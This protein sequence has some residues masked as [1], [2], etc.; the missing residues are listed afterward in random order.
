MFLI[1][2]V[3]EASMGTTKSSKE[4]TKPTVDE[5]VDR[6]RHQRNSLIAELLN[7]SKL[8]DYFIGS[9]GKEPSAIKTEFLKRDLKE[10]QSSSIDLAHYA[11]LIKQMKEATEV[12]LPNDSLFIQEL[13][14]IFKKYIY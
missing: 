12:S 4:S 1:N 10:L 13:D 7:E 8:K 5:I 2:E 3:F 14:V 11:S 6:I 9:Y